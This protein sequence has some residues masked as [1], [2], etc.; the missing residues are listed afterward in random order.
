MDTT[1]R[2]ILPLL[3]A[4]LLA[5]ACAHAGAAASAVPREQA[6]AALDRPD[7]PS[8]RDALMR[9]GEIGTMADAERVAARL[10]DDEVEVH[11]AAAAA[12]WQIWSRSGDDAIDALFARGLDEM[13][14]GRFE[15]ALATYSEIVRRRPDFAEGWNKRATVLFLMG[16]HVQSLHDCDEV[17]ARN[18]LHFGA[19]SGAAQIHLKMGR[20]EQARDDLERA[21]RVYPHLD[22]A[23]EMI[24]LIDRHRARLRSGGT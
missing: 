24:E 2:R 9:L 10:A 6:L 1:F 12:L 17:L 5:G 22:G 16:R 4:A 18:R 20:F 11:Q 13:S 21:L 7:A 15:A 3:L 19:L 14:N 8:R 23:R